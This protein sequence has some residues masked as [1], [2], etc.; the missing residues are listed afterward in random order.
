MPTNLELKDPAVKGLQTTAVPSIDDTTLLTQFKEKSI[1]NKVNNIFQEIVTI[2]SYQP[3]DLM[4]RTLNIYKNMYQGQPYENYSLCSFGGGIYADLLLP[5]ISQP[6]GIFTENEDDNQDTIHEYNGVFSFQ[7][8]SRMNDENYCCISFIH[9]HDGIRDEYQIISRQFN[10]D[11]SIPYAF[12]KAVDLYCQLHE[13]KSVDHPF[14][15]GAM[16]L[17]ASTQG[18]EF[19]PRNPDDITDWFLDG[20]VNYL[21]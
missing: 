2:D 3:S 10:E 4:S 6:S 13:I 20:V 11:T 19:Y 14:I 16:M 12:I 18:T 21:A 8:E 5:D 17:S 15:F 7:S 1:E 9:K